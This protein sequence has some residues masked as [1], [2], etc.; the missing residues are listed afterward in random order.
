MS[1]IKIFTGISGVYKGL[2]PTIMKQG[3]NQAMRFFLMETMKDWYKGGDK[4]KKVPKATI[5][6]MGIVAGILLYRYFIYLKLFKL[7]LS[8]II[9]LIL[10]S[11]HK[12][13]IF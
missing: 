3:S 6:C 5:G 8:L 7:Q 13:L 10:F 12:I 2:L 11:H 9:F 4:T 1:S